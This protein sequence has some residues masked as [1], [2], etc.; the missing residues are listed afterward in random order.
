ME[1]SG[2][3]PGRMVKTRGRE[4]AG[5]N[6]SSGTLSPPLSLCARMMD[7]V[8]SPLHKTKNGSDVDALQACAG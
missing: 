2:T 6:P 7:S 1:L 8:S 5:S 4:V 3:R